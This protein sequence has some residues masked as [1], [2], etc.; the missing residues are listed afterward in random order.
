MKAKSRDLLKNLTVLGQSQKK[1]REESQKEE[2]VLPSIKQPNQGSASMDKLKPFAP[3]FD[4]RT[5]F[6]AVEIQE[7]KLNEPNVTWQ[8]KNPKE[9]MSG[10]TSARELLKNSMPSVNNQKDGFTNTSPLQ[11]SRFNSF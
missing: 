10:L 11:D 8:R 6:K 4:E 5:I 1:Q 9:T 7:I 2:S 3:N